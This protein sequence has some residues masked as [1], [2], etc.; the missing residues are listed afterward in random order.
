MPVVTANPAPA[1]GHAMGVHGASRR[2]PKSPSSNSERIYSAK[3]LAE[4]LK[5]GVAAVIDQ[6]QVLRP[7]DRERAYAKRAGR[8]LTHAWHGPTVASGV[9]VRNCC[10]A[11]TPARPMQRATTLLRFT[12]V[13]PGGGAPCRCWPFWTARLCRGQVS[14][15]P[16]TTWT[17]SQVRPARVADEARM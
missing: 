9:C 2:G 7:D 8:W 10:S 4:A 6:L 5:S 12:G 11:L 14:A 1:G 17:S 13:A 16:L 15:R 3:Q